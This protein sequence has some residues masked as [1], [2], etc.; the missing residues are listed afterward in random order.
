MGVV[1]DLQSAMM[2]HI[3]LCALLVLAS[4][5]ILVGKQ[6]TNNEERQLLT[7]L[8]ANLFVRSN[9][10]LPDKDQAPVGNKEKIETIDKYENQEDNTV[11]EE[12]NSVD[13]A[14]FD[15]YLDAFYTKLNRNLKARMLEPMTINFDLLDK[16]IV[17]TMNENVQGLDSYDRTN[18]DNKKFSARRGKASKEKEKKKKSTRSKNN[19][20][21][22]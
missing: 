22:K 17:Y 19:K 16:E 20:K 11:V 7:S 3:C 14:R 4:P 15:R 5:S 9:Q 8:L 10:Q 1:T 12:Q 18:E 21:E 2:G 6:V 13:V